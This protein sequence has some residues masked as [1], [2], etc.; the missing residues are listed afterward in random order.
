MTDAWDRLAAVLEAENGALERLDLAR[1][2]G[3]LAAKQAALEAIENAP[4]PEQS[5]LA[6]TGELARANQCLLEHGIAIQAR[7]LALVAEAART[8]MA[9][10][11]PAPCYGNGTTSASGAPMAPRDGAPMVLSRTV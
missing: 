5:R 7:V 3:M 4:P 8:A 1:A 10:E 11:A 6:A 2:A 9:S